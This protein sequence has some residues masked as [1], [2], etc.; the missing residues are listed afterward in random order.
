MKYII[1]TILVKIESLFKP[2]KYNYK[3]LKDHTAWDDMNFHYSIFFVSS[4][5]LFQNRFMNFDDLLNGCS[6]YFCKHGE[7]ELRGLNFEL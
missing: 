1:T 5:I 3:V 2:K 6:T 4:M 7:A